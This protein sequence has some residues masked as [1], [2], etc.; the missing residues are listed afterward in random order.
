[1]SGLAEMVSMALNGRMGPTQFGLDLA[2]TGLKLDQ[3]EPLGRSF[4]SPWFDSA[5]GLA[6]SSFI[7]SSNGLESVLPVCYNVQPSPAVTSKIPGF[8]DETLFYMFYAMPGD[9]MQDLAARE[10]YSR[11]WRYHKE[12]KIWL[13]LVDES[14]GSTNGGPP[15]MISP[16]LSILPPKKNAGAA[17]GSA[18]LIV[19]GDGPRQYTVFD[20]Q[21]WSKI[22]KELPVRADQLEDRFAPGN[23]ATLGSAAPAATPVL[24]SVHRN[25]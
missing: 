10:L 22:T 9:R 23:P 1:M 15:T 13:L 24:L 3:T 4:V 7:G 17:G 14:R 20:P 5:A 18:P 2:V 25:K 16:D 11:T 8:A 12:L 6:S 21:S 19:L